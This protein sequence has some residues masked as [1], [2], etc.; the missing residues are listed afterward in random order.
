MDWTRLE[1]VFRPTSLA[2]ASRYPPNFQRPIYQGLYGDQPEPNF[3]S[4]KGESWSGVIPSIHTGD[5]RANLA[6]MYQ[7]EMGRFLSAE[8]ALEDIQQV[9]DACWENTDGPMD[10]LRIDEL[11]YLEG[12]NRQ[13][14]RDVLEVAGP[15]IYV[16][17]HSTML[18][19]YGKAHPGPKEE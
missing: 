5:Y 13:A 16:S 18:E 17:I 4:E 12:R 3:R 9:V 11:H 7:D 10:V 8:P 6:R 19:V 15:R 2:S 14:A 1:G